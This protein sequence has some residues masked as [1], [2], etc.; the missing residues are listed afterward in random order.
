MQSHVERLVNKEPWRANHGQPKN[1]LDPTWEGA[2]RP[3]CGGDIDYERAQPDGGFTGWW[4]CTT[5]GYCG[6][7]TSVIHAVVQH[8]IEYFFHSLVFYYRKRLGQ[9]AAPTEA[10]HQA[11]FTAGM[12]LRYAAT[13]SPDQLRSYTQQLVLQ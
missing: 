2:D 4:F 12:A 1:A 5:C 13:L 8:P 6:H 7:G 11:M 9:G 3:F 10:V